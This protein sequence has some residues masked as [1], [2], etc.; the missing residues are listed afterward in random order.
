MPTKPRTR[1][2]EHSGNEESTPLDNFILFI[3]TICTH[4]TGRRKV[5]F[6]RT[7]ASYIHPLCPGLAG[8]SKIV[9]IES[10]HY[11]FFYNNKAKCGD[12]QWF[13][14]GP[15]L[16]IVSAYQTNL[17]TSTL[18]AHTY[19]KILNSFRKPCDLPAQ[20]QL[21]NRII[22]NLSRNLQNWAKGEE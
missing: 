17:N 7:S 6:T 14:I 20:L 5:A 11:L 12:Q 19:S 22:C 16:K 15:A 8:F 9:M 3:N 2:R 10:P 13:N 1:P 21:K 4:R 18:L